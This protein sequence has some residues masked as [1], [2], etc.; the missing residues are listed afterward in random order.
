M[1]TKQQ[2]DRVTDEIEIFVGGLEVVRLEGQRIVPATASRE[3]E[4]LF[5]EDLVDTQRRDALALVV[6]W[7]GFSEGQKDS[8]IQRVLDGESRDSWMDG[9][10]VTKGHDDGKERFRKIL[11]EQKIDY[12]AAGLRDTGQD[13]EQFLKE[14]TERAL[15]RMQGKEGREI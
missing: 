5:W 11:E 9:I 7:R 12:Q 10:D 3:G 13:Y 15:T 4:Y 8:V 1:P 14:A 2:L 6:D